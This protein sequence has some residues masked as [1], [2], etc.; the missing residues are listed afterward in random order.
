MLLVCY[1]GNKITSHLW[2]VMTTALSETESYWT[3][4]LVFLKTASKQIDL[5]QSENVTTLVN[6][7]F[8][9]PTCSCCCQYMVREQWVLNWMGFSV[10]V[11]D[12]RRRRWPSVSAHPRRLSARYDRAVPKTVVWQ[13]TQLELDPIRDSKPMEFTEQWSCV[14]WPPCRENQSRRGVQDGL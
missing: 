14:V 13:H 8:I 1:C 6:T 2:L 10:S 11:T 5:C 12:E 7:S 4:T 9:T 3:E